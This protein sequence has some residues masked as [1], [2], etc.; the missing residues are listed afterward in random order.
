MRAAS[1]HER[2]LVPTI[3]RMMITPIGWSSMPAC[4]LVDGGRVLGRADRAV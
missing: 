1:L 4:G 3:S 2:G